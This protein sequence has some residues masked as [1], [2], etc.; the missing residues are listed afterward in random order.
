MLP[1]IPKD[2]YDNNLG[3]GRGDGFTVTGVPG[4]TVTGP[5][6]DN[7]DGSYTVPVTCDP[8]TG[9]NPGVVIGQP[10]RPPIIV[11]GPGS[12]KDRCGNWKILFWIMLPAT[13][14]LLLFCILK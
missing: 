9:N 12:G 11:H 13:L 7:G 10:G 1:F 4:T 14:F 6:K 3:P 8:S 5:V 2:K